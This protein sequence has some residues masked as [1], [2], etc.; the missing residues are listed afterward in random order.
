[1][2][3]VYGGEPLRPHELSTLLDELDTLA[4]DEHVAALAAALGTRGGRPTLHRRRRG[5]A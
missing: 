2:G 3:R 1:M 4:A 5:Q